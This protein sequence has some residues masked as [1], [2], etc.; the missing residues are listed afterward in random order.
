MQAASPPVSAPYPVQLEG[1]LQQP[2]RWLWLVKWLLVLP[3][4][5]VLAFLWIAFVL[6]SLLAFVSLLFGGSYP[7]GIFEFNLGVLRWSWRV[8]FYAFGANGTDRYPPFTLAD[9][10][11]Y[12]ARLHVE[13]PEQQ[14]HGLPLIGWWLVGI[15]QYVVACIFAGAPASIGWTATDHRWATPGFGGLIGFLVFVA[16]LVLLFRGQYPRSMFDFVLGLNRWV[17]RVGAYA[18]LM[19]PEYPPF[20]F[21]GGER[22]PGS[23]TIEPVTP[24]GPAAP[25]ATVTPSSWGAG[26]VIG[27][28]VATLVVLVG[29]AG[30]AA[31]GTALVFDQ[32]Q[33]DSSGY[34]MT[35]PTAYSTDTYALVSDSYRT[36]AA[37]DWFV[38]RDMLGTVRIRTDSPRP[39]FV[40]IGPAAAVDAYLAGVRREVANPFDAAR[41]HFRLQQGGAPT[42]PPTAKRFWAAHTIG[43]GTQTLKWSPASGDWRIVVMNADKSAGI[44]ADL[45]I[46]ARFP[47]LLW[48]GI[49][50]LAGGALLLLIGGGGLYAAVRTRGR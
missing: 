10:P 17:I 28:I 26:R 50:V 46:G 40:G 6:L 31:G 47:H 16:A 1:H 18:A 4:Y 27:V 21:D 35:G 8:A 45:A 20:R 38:A 15:P 34:L 29:L 49:G 3:H 22:E 37:R 11:D 23:V 41:S 44:H 25:T 32:T 12:P 48:I 9:V 14:R 24:T 30:L 2:S 7:R 43:A 33:R 42:V 13:Y 39:V 36:G 19:T 5:V